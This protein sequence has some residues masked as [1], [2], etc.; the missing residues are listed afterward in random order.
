MGNTDIQKF[1]IITGKEK[2]TGSCEE[3]VEK[4]SHSSPQYLRRGIRCHIVSWRTYL[5]YIGKYAII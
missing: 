4:L 5:T 3:L 1:H 2:P